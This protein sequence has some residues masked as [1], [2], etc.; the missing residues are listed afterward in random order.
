MSENTS[1]STEL[2]SQYT[3]QVTTDLE[4]NLKEQERIHQEIAALQ[5]Q[6]TTLQ[7]DHA[8]LVSMHQALGLTVPTI[9]AAPAPAAAAPAKK[10]RARKAPQ[11]KKG[12]TAKASASATTKAEAKSAEPTLVSL[13]RDHLA[14]Q[15]EPRSTAEIADTM[16]Q[17]HP[18]RGIKAT[19]VRT[20]L[21][22]LVAKGLVQ[23]VKQGSSVYYTA[24]DAAQPAEEQ[25]STDAQTDTAS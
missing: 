21:E 13:I 1:T 23:R 8:V 22:G 12:T 5:E 4:H 19:V 14:A 20:T 16:G 10:A 7:H 11:P 24:S 6:L 2:T 25:A 17:T 18:D 15:S 3:A 9:E